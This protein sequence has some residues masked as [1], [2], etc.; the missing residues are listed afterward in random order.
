MTMKTF[1]VY[2]VTRDGRR[3]EDRNYSSIADAKARAAALKEVLAEWDPTGVKAVS[4]VK[5]DKPNRIR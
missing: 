1:P 2:V 5:T 4:V 3:T